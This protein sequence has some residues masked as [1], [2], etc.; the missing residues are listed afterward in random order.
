MP[1][2]SNKN[3][4]CGRKW[5]DGA[6]VG[7]KDEAKDGWM[8]CAEIVVLQRESGNEVNIQTLGMYR[9]SLFSVKHP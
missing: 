1:N 4:C 6:M 9:T 8:T 3:S 5:M 7:A 2:L